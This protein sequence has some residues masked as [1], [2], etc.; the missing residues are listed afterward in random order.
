MKYIVELNGERKSV[1]LEPDGVS[2]RAIL[3]F[4]QNS[5]TSRRVPSEW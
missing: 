1:A 5:S 3:R 4:T 2:T